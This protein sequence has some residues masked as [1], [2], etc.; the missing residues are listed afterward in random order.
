M[1][2]IWTGKPRLAR[3]A[4]ASTDAVSPAV[5]PSWSVRWARASAPASTVSTCVRSTSGAGR[6]APRAVHEAPRRVPSRD[7]S[8]TTT[9][10]ST[11]GAPRVR[12]SVHPIAGG[13]R[14]HGAVDR[15]IEAPRK[16]RRRRRGFGHTDVTFSKNPPA[17]GV[18][19]ADVIP[20]TG[21]DTMWSSQHVAYEQLAAPLRALIDTLDAQHAPVA[22][23]RRS[24]SEDGRRHRR[25]ARE[26][27]PRGAPGGDHASG[28]RAPGALREPRLHDRHRGTLRRSRAST[29]CDCCSRTASNRATRRVGSG[30]PAISRSGTSAPRSTSRSATTSPHTAACAA[31]PSRSTP[32]P[33]AGVELERGGED[34]D[35]LVGLR[36]GADQR[37]REPQ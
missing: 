16:S 33:P 32:R 9:T 14:S 37:R 30:R 24:P 28:H 26:V 12:L 19:L 13:V 4:I 29:C 34:L 25:A 7:S 2:A 35:G 21:G 20:G 18:L 5:S 23:S 3:S 1:V 10:R 31:A 15:V 36:L 11:T 6:V 8:S 27:L 17:F 22:F